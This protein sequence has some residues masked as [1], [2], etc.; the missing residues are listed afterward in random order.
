MYRSNAQL[1]PIFN[2][3]KNIGYID[4]MGAVIIPCEYDGEAKFY[5]FQIKNKNLIGF[6]LPHWAYFKNNSVTLKSDKFSLK[7]LGNIIRYSLVD[8]KGNKIIDNSE[9]KIYGLSDGLAVCIYYLK[10]FQNIYDSFYTYID[11]EKNEML[12]KKYGFA[13]SF[14]NEFALVIENG[15]YHYINKN[16]ENTFGLNKIDDAKNFSEGLAAV[17]IDTLWG[18]I[19]TEGNWQI[20]PK[21]KSANNFNNGIAKV[22]LENT[23][24]YINSGEKII[25]EIM[26]YSEGLAIIEKNG[27]YVFADKSNNIVIDDRFDYATNFEN[28]LAKVWKNNE[29]Y[30]INKNGEKVYSILDKAQYKKIFNQ[31]DI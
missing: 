27:K 8:D 4:S 6:T 12:D 21:Y 28:G 24:E 20:K 16:F 31:K 23:F 17:K 15:E 30:Y 5:K 19:N 14:N 10:T 2:D 29:L 26:E 22:L 25:N 13:S 1:S 11:I 18:Y 7:H 9:N 3:K